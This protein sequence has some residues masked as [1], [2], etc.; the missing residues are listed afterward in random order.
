MLR[1]FHHIRKSLLE[2]NKVRS[3]LLYAAGEILLVV[4][5]IL[6]ALHVN[7][8]NQQRIAI[9][10]EIILLGEVLEALHADSLALVEMSAKMDSTFDVYTKLYRIS[11][12]ELPPDGL[13]E[14]DLMRASAT[15][16]PVSKATYPDLASKVM[17]NDIKK[18]IFEYYQALSIWEYIIEEYNRF[19]EEK[20]RPFL[21]E[22]QFLVYGYHY[23]GAI[24]REGKIDKLKLIGSLGRADVQQTLFE[25]TQKTRNYVDLYNTILSE[26]K[27]LINEIKRVYD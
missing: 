10:N 13:T 1:F 12:G 2:P 4:V 25:A 7:N 27:E 3:Y 6:I 19:T 23:T 8:W 5:G 24:G 18:R 16:K 11:Q 14:A 21:G 20:M 17:N 26:R 15:A 9:N 22:N